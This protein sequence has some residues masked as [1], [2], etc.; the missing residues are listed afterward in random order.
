MI[1]NNPPGPVEF[2][3]SVIDEMATWLANHPVVQ[4]EDEA[5]EAK[6]LIDRTRSALVDI[7]AKRTALVAPLNE[8]VAKINSD[9]KHYHNT[10]KNRPGLFDKVLGVMSA[11]GAGL[12]VDRRSPAERGKPKMHGRPLKKPSVLRGKPKPRNGKLWITLRRGK[13][14]LMLWP[15]RK[16]PIWRS[17]TSSGPVVLQPWLTRQRKLRLL[18]GLASHYRFARKKS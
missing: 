16:G 3:Q 8:K 15:P 6:V 12:H 17:M 18:A 5:R 14:V 4:T 11:A 13:L 9:H 10:D 2:A 7:E 1:S